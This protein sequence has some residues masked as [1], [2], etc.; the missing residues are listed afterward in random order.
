MLESLK[1]VFRR[2][3]LLEKVALQLEETKVQLLNSLADRERVNSE[4]SCYTTRIARL[5]T[6]IREAVCEVR[7]S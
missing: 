6:F 7:D 5:E 1:K 4:V 2:R 3:T